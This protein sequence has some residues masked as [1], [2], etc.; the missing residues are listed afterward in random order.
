MNK[1]SLSLCM[2]VRDEE[3]QLPR[4]LDS[5]KSVVDEMVIVDTGSTDRTIGIAE[6]YGAKVIRHQ[7]SNDFAAARNAGLEKAGGDWILVLDA[8]EVLDSYGC[9][10]LPLYMMHPGIEG[11][12][13]QLHNYLNEDVIWE[14]M[15]NPALRLFRN[16]PEYRY[17]HP[18]HE[19]V[20]DSIAANSEGA[21]LGQT[22]LVIHH[23]GYGQKQLQTKQKIQRNRTALEQILVKEP[24]NAFHLFNRGVNYC[25]TQEH[26]KAV[27]CFRQSRLYGPQDSPFRSAAYLHEIM[28]LFHLEQVTEAISTAEAGIKEYEDYTD[29]YHWQGILQLQNEETDAAERA[30]TRALSLGSSGKYVTEKGNGTFR[31]LWL[32]GKL[33]QD[34]TQYD[35]AISYYTAAI[36]ME[37]VF[38]PALR[39]L[40][41][42][43]NCCGREQELIQLMGRLMRV[44]GPE[45]RVSML[46]TLAEANCYSTILSITDKKGPHT[47]SMAEALIRF[48]ALLMTGK[49]TEAK[50]FVQSNPVFNQNILYKDEAVQ[51]LTWM[52]KGFSVDKLHLPFTGEQTEN[53]NAA[54]AWLSFAAKTAKANGHQ[55]TSQSITGRWQAALH[56]EPQAVQNHYA[57]TLL[58]ETLMHMA[59]SCLIDVHTDMQEEE[60]HQLLFEARIRLQASERIVH[61]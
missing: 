41:H 44:Y 28:S 14:I 32:M 4:C 10:L 37:P 51:W 1:P 17:R 8:D 45:L 22:E 15:V 60:T 2:I 25:Q 21:A 29:L 35:Q 43:L 47:E 58:A 38:Y 57:C 18:I 9:E 48:Q 7:W 52:E 5:V 12:L 54:A 40:A 61:V 30:F 34:R 53:E 55:H 26:D 11:I 27:D 6:Q 39:A 23:Y 56:K 59:E 33:C 46:A 19:Q 20:I 42:V 36:E 49:L 16:R 24:T 13:F 31:T 3:E 50:K